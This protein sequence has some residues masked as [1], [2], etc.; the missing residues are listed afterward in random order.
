MVN[1][2]QMSFFDPASPPLPDVCRRKHGGEPRSKEA[3]RRAQPGK[4]VMR[5]R[6]RVYVAGCGW[7][8]ATSGEIEQAFNLAKNKFSGRLTE[9]R[10]AGAIWK[11]RR[12]RD[13]C[14]V[15]VGRESWA[16]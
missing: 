14:N 9:L 6:I 2:T 5:E 1:V 13:G 3:N 10:K 12:Q 11:A 15:F 7:N 8:G 16:N 4:A